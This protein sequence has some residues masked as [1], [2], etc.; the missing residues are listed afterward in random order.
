MGSSEFALPALRGLAHSGHEVTAVYTCPARP[1][2][3]GQKTRPGIIETFAGHMGL[4]V[5]TPASLK[6]PAVQEEF[7]AEKPDAAIVASYGLL[8]PPAILSTPRLGCLNIHPSL[9]PRWRGAA[10]IPRQ[11]EAGDVHTG[12]TIMQMDEGLDT[13]PV[14]L[15]EKLEMQ[16]DITAGELHDFLAG[17][18]GHMV[19]RA[20]EGLHKGTLTPRPQPDSGATY[21]EKITKNEACID[22]SLP[23]R[24]LERKIRAFN[25]RPG[26][27]FD[28]K[29]E[30][31]KVFSAQPMKINGS[32]PPGTILDDQLTVAC[33][34]DALRL[35]IVQRPGRKA[36][37]AQEMLRG[38]HLEEEPAC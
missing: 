10:P 16:P 9:L 34:E 33:G 22:W 4:E 37:A 7:A 38:F 19:L 21:A 6:D 23:A 2:G 14:L 8:L 5:K 28:Y 24:V 25:P 29:G 27:F 30:A 36:M 32:E 12:V 17:M 20:L 35:K 13:G 11:I 1:A 15:Q 26:A 31:V 18:G 3:R